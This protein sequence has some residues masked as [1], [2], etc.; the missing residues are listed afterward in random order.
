MALKQLK[1]NSQA[2]ESISKYKLLSAYGGPGSIVHTQYGSI[3]ISCIE[4][5]GFLKKILEIEQEAISLGKQDEAKEE[6]V[7][8]QAK[9][10]RNGNIGI[11]NDKR[12]L[13]KLIERKGFNKD[14]FKYLVLIP[15]IDIKE[16]NNEISDGTEL[17]IP[18]T[19]MPKV[20]A[21]RSKIHKTYKEW[22][23]EWC[24]VNKS[25]NGDDDRYGNLFFPPKKNWN[26]EN[27][28]LVKRNWSENLNQ[29][30]IV[31][32]C[33]HGH[34]SDF[35]WSQFLGWR[36]EF[37]TAIYD[38]TPVNLFS[39]PLCCGTG[40]HPTAQIIIT[41]NAA[42]SSGFDGK[43]LKCKCCSKQTSLKGLMSVKIKCLGH[44]PWEVDTGKSQFYSGDNNVR[45]SFPRGEPCTS[46]NPL[47]VALTTGNNLYYS[48][49]MSSIF[50]PDELF[51]SEN[52]L[53]IKKLEN[54][55]ASLVINKDYAGAAL[56]NSKVTELRAVINEG[57]LEN[58][59]DSEKEIQ[60]RHQEFTAFRNKLVDE[61][62]ISPKFLKVFDVTSNLKGDIDLTSYFS[63]VLR[64]DNMKITSALLD[65]SRV[66]PAD[67]DASE[68]LSKNI[69]RGNPEQIQVY[70][71]V[72]N[73]GEGIFFSF[74]EEMIANFS[75]KNSFF[76]NE[77]KAKL[78][79][80]GADDFSIQAVSYGKF[81][82]W[83]LYLIHTFSHL[84][85]RELEFRCGYPTASLSERIYV[86]NEE[87]Y[88]MYG[89]MIYT[90][91]GAEGSMGGLIAQTRGSNLINLI[92]SALKRSTICHSDPLCWES[93]GQGL[94]DMNFASC[95]SCGLVS[96]TSCELRNIY[97]DRK[98][99]ID[100]ESGFFKDNIKD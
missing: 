42:N 10:Q 36:T 98:I 57:V 78:S 21:D 100:E 97:L 32:I 66:A 2:N 9:L 31:L 84:I 90:A 79:E 43:I 7:I 18:S 75:E 46:L 34:M 30:N 16:Y 50:M 24:K 82:G 99:L 19:F 72:E 38:D 54:Q 74:N 53:E 96:E 20:F 11:S 1:K 62:N 71:V 94:F 49:A 40:E 56:L 15:N 67:A 44:R 92:K 27:G 93:E 35:P 70:P 22:F 80:I 5:W 25:D 63:R 85:M 3:L 95:F 64:I 26:E 6:Y 4:E 89:C 52:K 55:I 47:K 73:F 12:L 23:N 83:Q 41:S 48:R 58:I 45:N 59:P 88:K 68:L 81:H 86:S 13:Q 17:A 76:I 61:I 37:P 28:A 51:E 14:N 91:E 39:L 77:W 29:D 60:F 87:K 69:F 65:F 33:D 8:S